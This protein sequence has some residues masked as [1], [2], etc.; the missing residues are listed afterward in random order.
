MSPQCQGLLP[1]P[2]PTDPYPTSPPLGTLCVFS[3]VFKPQGDLERS[4]TLAPFAEPLKGLGGREQQKQDKE[5]SGTS[6]GPPVCAGAGSG[7]TSAVRRKISSG[8]CRIPPAMTP[9]ATP[10]NT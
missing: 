2:P 5:S 9:R 6:A 4:V 1:T 8:M 3:E 10:G 7:D